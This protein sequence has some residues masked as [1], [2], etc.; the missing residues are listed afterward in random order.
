MYKQLY[1]T[2]FNDITDTL[3]HLENQNFGQAINLLKESQQKCED[4][5]MESPEKD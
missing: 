2:L 5:Y 3:E 1:M 4:I